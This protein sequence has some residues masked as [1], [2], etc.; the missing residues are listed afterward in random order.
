MG[1]RQ[2]PQET[3]PIVRNCKREEKESNERHADR[4]AGIHHERYSAHQ[5]IE[6]PCQIYPLESSHP[7]ASIHI[8]AHKI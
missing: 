5:K 1:F 3:S 4:Q 6:K 7:G 2:G 8:N